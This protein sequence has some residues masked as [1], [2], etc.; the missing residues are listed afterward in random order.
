MGSKNYDGSKINQ[1]DFRLIHQGARIEITS[2][3][4]VDTTV[5]NT[6][7]SI[8]LSLYT[9]DGTSSG[10]LSWEYTRKISGEHVSVS[11]VE[12]A[13]TLGPSETVTERKVF[14]LPPDRGATTNL[15]DWQIFSSA[16]EAVGA[17]VGTTDTDVTPS[18]TF[19][20]RPSYDG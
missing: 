3:S 10:N 20:E 9:S 14:F 5:L 6:S 19:N 16:G 15:S 4:G 11:T 1:P 18:G 12:V 17:A 13:S 7:T 8:E 2:Q